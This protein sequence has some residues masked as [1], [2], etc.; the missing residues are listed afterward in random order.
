MRRR[1]SIAATSPSSS[2]RRRHLHVHDR[3]IRPVRE[4]PCAAGRRVA[5]LATTSSPA[6]AENPAIPSR[7][8]TSSSPIDD[9]QRPRRR[10]ASA[11]RSS[12]RK[13]GP[14]S[15]P[16][17]GSRWRLPAG[18]RDVGRVRRPRRSARREPCHGIA[19]ELPR[20]REAV[21]V[22][23]RRRRPA[24]CRDA[25]RWL[26][27]TASCTLPASPITTWPHPRHTLAARSRNE[28]SSSTTSTER[29]T[30]HRPSPAPLGG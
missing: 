16:W 5:G 14:A 20:Q 8:R 11:H 12:R 3:D 13:R 4:R 19:R 2:S 21:A 7:S 25:A 9:A 26:R 30:G 28:A 24:R 10:H 27:A 29:G 6:P 22:R 15:R 23:Q 17:G 18:R 1:S